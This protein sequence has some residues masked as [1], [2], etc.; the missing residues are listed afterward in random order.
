MKKIEISIDTTEVKTETFIL[1]SSSDK[2]LAREKLRRG[3]NQS[4]FLTIDEGDTIYI[5]FENEKT[6]FLVELVMQLGYQLLAFSRNSTHYESWFAT[7]KFKNCMK[8]ELNVG[9]KTRFELKFH[10]ES[11][12]KPIKY[13]EA[14][15]SDYNLTERKELGDV[16]KEYVKYVATVILATMA[17]FIVS[18]LLFLDDMKPDTVHVKTPPYIIS[19]FFG[20]LSIIHGSRALSSSHKQY[21]KM[22]K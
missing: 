9:Y 15:W 19:L 18:V 20:T 12:D 10:D 2:L 1:F 14:K 3:L 5:S 11:V 13:L 16:K 17:T 8:Y 6:P 7:F 21:Q 4:F 22:K